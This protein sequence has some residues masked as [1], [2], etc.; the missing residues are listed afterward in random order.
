MN[1]MI[2]LIDLGVRRHGLAN[3]IVSRAWLVMHLLMALPAQA[4]EEGGQ[5]LDQAANDPTAFILSIQLSDWYTADF[6]N[7]QDESANSVVLRAA[8]PFEFKGLSN[9]FRV[10]APVATHHPALGSG[11]SDMTLFDLVVFDKPWGRW[12]VGP[13]ML[14]PTGGSNRG[15]DKW[16]AGPA[17]GFTAR[18]EKLIW[19]FSTRTC[20]LSVAMTSARMST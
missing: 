4:Q 16:A 8:Y 10:T 18:K 17:L 15:A 2:S 9:I 1:H 13:V 3:S 19:E 11:L 20:S 12:G 6:W 14:V 5:S 7:L